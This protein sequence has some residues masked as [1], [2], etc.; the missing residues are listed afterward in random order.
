VLGKHGGDRKSEDQVDNVKLKHEGGNH[1]TYLIARLARDHP[2][3]SRQLEAGGYPSVRAA[4]IEAGIVKPMAQIRTDD[5]TR[6]AAAIL[7][8]FQGSRLDALIHAL[9]E[10]RGCNR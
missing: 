2:A 4:A 6:A 1:S 7:R 3:I 5:P 10:M 8:H 9:A